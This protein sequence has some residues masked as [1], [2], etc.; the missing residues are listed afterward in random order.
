MLALVSKV[1]LSV[2]GKLVL[3]CV[4]VDIPIVMDTC[5]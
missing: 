4:E 1:I 2:A 5:L 3:E